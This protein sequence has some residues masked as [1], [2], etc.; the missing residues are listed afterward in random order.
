MVKVL[1]NWEEI[2]R[3]TKFLEREGLPRH[4]SSEKCWDYHRLFEV[5]KDFPRSAAILDMGCS[6][7]HT[8]R[9]LHAMGFADLTGIDLHISP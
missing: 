9:F 6:G 1:Q 8:L 5:V 2:G 4:G 3:A 7:V